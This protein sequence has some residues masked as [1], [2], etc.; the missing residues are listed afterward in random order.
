M[1][2]EFPNI[3]VSIQIQFEILIFKLDLKVVLDML[4]NLSMFSSYSDALKLLAL[5][6][7]SLLN[8]NR[9]DIHEQSY[10]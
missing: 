7:N 3:F 4:H 6:L 8:K 1:K 9:V 5:K 2:L 10:I